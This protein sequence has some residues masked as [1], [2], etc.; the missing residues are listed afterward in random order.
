MLR[1]KRPETMQKNQMQRE[2]RKRNGKKVKR[3]VDIKP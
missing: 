3:E 2:D 1:G